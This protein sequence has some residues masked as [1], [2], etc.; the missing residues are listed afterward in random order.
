MPEV[1]GAVV[2]APVSA[3]RSLVAT[4]IGQTH[5]ASAR[6]AL[7]RDRAA[8]AAALVLLVVVVFAVAA[9]WVSTHDPLETDPAHRL[10]PPLSGGYL[11]GSDELGRD[12]FSRLAFGGRTSLVVALLPVSLAVLLGGAFGL[13]A[14]YFG[15]WLDALLLRLMDVLLA[16]PSVLLAV[17]IAAA[18]GPGIRNMMVAMVIIGVPVICRLVRAST[19]QVRQLDYVQ[20]ARALGATNARIVLR[21]VTPNVVAP[22]IVFATLETGR[23]VILA[24]GLSFLGLGVQPPDPDWGA[25]LSSGRQSMLLGPHVATIPGLLICAVTL[26]FNVLGDGLRDALDPRLRPA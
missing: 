24:A 16:F 10:M 18:L 17:G 2:D 22:V 6:R 19:L 14:G 25:M 12:I 13:V 23:M 3:V 21:Q 26:A 9:P 1:V 15:G 4:R 11:L 8:T 7:V 5:A 20:A